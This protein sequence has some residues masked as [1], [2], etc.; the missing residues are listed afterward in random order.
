MN[1][2]P[3][4]Q[5][6]IEHGICVA[7]GQQDA[8]PGRQ[9]CPKCLEKATLSNIKYRSL[10]RERTYYPRRKEKRMARIAD[11]LCPQCGRPA[12]VG[13]LCLECYAKK[14]RRREAEKTE[15]AQRGDP[16]KARVN[17]GKC[18][19]CEAQALTGKRVCAKHYA[20]ILARFHSSARKEGHPWE[21]DEAI[22]RLTHSSA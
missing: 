3:L 2:V 6:Y 5:W 22:R 14:C 4:R 21:K 13:Q 7:C 20:D 19:F 16:R 17:N 1:Q 9:K 18:Y 15:R 8:F 10:E 11:G 12:K